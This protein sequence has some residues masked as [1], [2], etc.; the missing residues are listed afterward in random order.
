MHLTSYCL[1][2]WVKYG[3]R[4]HRQVI[5]W[6][7]EI[8]YL[9]LGAMS[10]ESTSQCFRMSFKGRILVSSS[11]NNHNAHTGPSDS[12]HI[13]LWVL[14]KVLYI[15]YFC[16]FHSQHICFRVKNWFL[17]VE[18]KIEGILGKIRPERGLVLIW[19]N[20]SRWKWNL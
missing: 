4:K 2:K 15:I 8:G 12:R 5:L 9:Y 13:S 11:T 16:I 17:F 3:R 19:V 18:W 7:L 10:M 1:I 14:F 20:V 6:N